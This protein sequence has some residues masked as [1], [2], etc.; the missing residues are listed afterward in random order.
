MAASVR[1][2]TNTTIIVDPTSELEEGEED[3]VLPDDAD[4]LGGAVITDVVDEEGPGRA[5]LTPVAVGLVMIVWAMHLRFLTR[6][7][8]QAAS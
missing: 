3:A 7:A 4:Q 1:P 8:A 2:P 5:V 6:Q